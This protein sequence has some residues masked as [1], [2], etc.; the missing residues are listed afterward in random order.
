MSVAALPNPANK[1]VQGAS[2][3]LG[4]GKSE[5][6]LVATAT[7]LGCVVCRVVSTPSNF[8]KFKHSYVETSS[9]SFTSFVMLD[10][11]DTSKLVANETHKRAA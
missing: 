3:Q 10:T 1:L 9:V 2:R 4:N 7:S 8:D 5:F 11:F 6:V